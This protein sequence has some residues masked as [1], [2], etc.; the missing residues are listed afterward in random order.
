[1]VEPNALLSK[2]S[3]IEK[4][5]LIE[6][7]IKG[8]MMGTIFF[9]RFK[10]FPRSSSKPLLLW[11]SMIFWASKA[12]VGINR[13]ANERVKVKE[14]GTFIA[15]RL[16]ARSSGWTVM[17]NRENDDISSMMRKHME[18]A[19]LNEFNHVFKMMMNNKM[20]VKPLSEVSHF[21]T[22][23]PEM[24]NGINVIMK[25]A[26]CT[27]SEKLSAKIE[28][29]MVMNNFVL[30]SK[31]WRNVSFFLNSKPLSRLIDILVFPLHVVYNALNHLIIV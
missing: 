20:K 9:T 13:V 2:A 4:A 1:M 21:R 25:N 6:L 10:R 17:K 31:E 7:M 11:A 28:Y 15:K 16:N 14:K 22:I 30:G 24:I 23:L 12:R 19:K 26:R 3:A 18:I 8:M 27:M 5:R 29:T